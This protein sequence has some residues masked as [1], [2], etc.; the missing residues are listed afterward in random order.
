MHQVSGLTAGLLDDARNRDY[1]YDGIWFSGTKIYSWGFVVEW[2]IPY[3]SIQ[4]DENLTEW[5]LDFDRYRPINSE[6]LYWNKYNKA[7]GQRISKFGKLVFENFHPT[8]HGLNLEVYPVAL[9]K[10]TYINDGKY[11]IDPEA[12]LDILYNPSPKL[13]FN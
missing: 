4:Y 2:K 12:G 10:A 11:K 13:N 7:E 8:V 9:T 1:N 3:K 5:G 6:D